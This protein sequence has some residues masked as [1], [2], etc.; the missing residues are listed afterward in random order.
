MA[1]DKLAK[2]ANLYRQIAFQTQAKRYDE[3]A[4]DRFALTVGADRVDQAL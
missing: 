3:L 4:T 2:Q 1:V